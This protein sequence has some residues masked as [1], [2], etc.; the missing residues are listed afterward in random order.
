MTVDTTTT[1][2]KIRTIIRD[3]QEPPEQVFT[4]PEIQVFY[5]LELT[6]KS[7]SAMA[8]ESMAS[9]EAL[10]FKVIKILDLS[11]NGPAVAAQLMKHAESLRSTDSEGGFDVIETADDPFTYRER[12]RKEF[13]RHG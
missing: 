4:D 7:A 1:I 13:Q 5:D 11:T 2:G 3:T 6:I 9:D 12:L 8:L 10:L